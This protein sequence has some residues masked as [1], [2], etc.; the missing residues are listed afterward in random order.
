MSA[1]KDGV[2]DLAFRSQYTADMARSLRTLCVH[3]HL[4]SYQV[5]QRYWIDTTRWTVGNNLMTP[6][7]KKKRI[8]LH[9]RFASIRDSLYDQASVSS[10][11]DLK[12]TDEDILS[13]VL[14]DALHAV[15]P[16]FDQP[17]RGSMT[18]GQIGGDSISSALFSSKL[19]QKGYQISVSDI[20]AFSLGHLSQILKAG[21]LFQCGHLPGEINWPEQWTLPWDLIDDIHS[22]KN[23]LS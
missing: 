18:F 5:P 15:F 6:T 9:Q 11:D 14:V 3:H 1:A 8:T 19:R 23:T 20:F 17:F 4:L 7:E 12:D 16:S 10:S 22:F 2:L 13:D 21:S